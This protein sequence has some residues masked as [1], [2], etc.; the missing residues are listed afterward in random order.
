MSCR[1]ACSTFTIQV[2]EEL[3]EGGKV[4]ALGE[5]VDDRLDA[6][7]SDL[8]EAELRPI[9]L[10]AHELGIESDIGRPLEFGDER[11]QFFGG[12]H[13]CHENGYSGFAGRG[14]EGFRRHAPATKRLE[15]PSL[16]LQPHRPPRDA[17]HVE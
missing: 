13:G 16:L 17:G 5:G 14:R 9:G 8:D 7:R 12:G 15:Q 4:D 1:E 11:F 2:I 10:V 6:G 3:V